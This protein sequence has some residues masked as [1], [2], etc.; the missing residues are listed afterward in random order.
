MKKNSVALLC[1][2]S[3]LFLSCSQQVE[4][5]ITPITK[6]TL[7]KM[8]SVY[9]IEDRA[10]VDMMILDSLLILI[11][12]K[13]SNYFHLYNS[14]TMKPLISFGGKGS[15]EFEF[16][17]RPLF[18]KQ[19]Y[20][21]IDDIEVYDILSSKKINIKN[22]LDG[23]NVA[24]EITS[25]RLDEKI[26]M[27]K[28]IINLDS[29]TIAG[30][31]LDNPD[32]LFYIFHTQS[33][34]KEWASFNP[35]PKIDKRY[36]SGLY[37]GLIEVSPDSET[38]VYCPRFFNR[39]LFFNNKGELFRRLNFSEVKAP[40]LSNEFFGVSHDELI[41]SYKSYPTKNFI[42]VLRPLQSLNNLNE[43]I[44]PIKV[45]ILRLTWEGELNAT[46]EVDLKIM[47][48]LFCVDEQNKKDTFQYTHRQLFIE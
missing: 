6:T 48:T 2:A 20:E 17:H 21:N 5:E 15:A 8:D 18:K 23:G 12:D 41:Y 4:E 24:K 36:H 45:Q 13:D 29:N 25:E 1:L 32:G 40:V 46:Y 38:I 35:K 47:P 19:H 39:I 37:Y 11:A 3:I 16:N 31:S 42:Y 10:Y 9:N 33:R 43:N 27:S 14:T 26:M 34:K 44:S 7:L 22:I 30:T 28:D